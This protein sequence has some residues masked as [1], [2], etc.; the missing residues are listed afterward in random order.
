MMV[1]IAV[2]VLT[3]RFEQCCYPGGCSRGS[4]WARC[5]E[6]S[7]DFHKHWVNIKSL[8]KMH[9]S[10]NFIECSM[11]NLCLNFSWS[12]ALAN[13]RKGDSIWNH[14]WFVTHETGVQTQTCF[15]L[16]QYVV[17][18]CLRIELLLFDKRT[19]WIKSFFQSAWFNTVGSS[20]GESSHLELRRWQ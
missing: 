5:R 8:P 13:N 4:E 16:N 7:V 20:G 6:C 12:L 15:D 2:M 3:S 10:F 14:L 18:L 17:D 9:R 1:V 11:D 19:N